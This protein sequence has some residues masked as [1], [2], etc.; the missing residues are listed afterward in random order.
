[1]NYL[2]RVKICC[3]SSAEEA[4]LAIRSGASAIGLV[5]R[6]PSGPGIIED[7][8]IQTISRKVPPPVA[9]FLLTSETTPERVLDHYHRV[10]TT[11]IQLVD[12]LEERKYDVIRNAIPHV[13]LVQVIHVQDERSLTEAVEISH[14]VDALLLDSGNP[15][16]KVKELGG[17]GRTHN[18]KVSRRIC[19]SVSI[20]VF[21]AGGLHAENIKEAIESVEPFG[22][23]VCSGVRTGGRLDPQKLQ[24]FFSAVGY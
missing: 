8:L 6:M 19:K 16:L 9:T 10:N 4:S 23:D 17:T 22:V 1:M 7:S 2:P 14:W 20:P 15:D 3:I 21:L 18:W 24:N 5:G 12:Q 11:T 13:K